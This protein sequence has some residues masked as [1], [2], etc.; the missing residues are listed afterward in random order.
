[1]FAG[2]RETSLRTANLASFDLHAPKLSFAEWRGCRGHQRCGAQ[3]FE[4]C[5]R[6]VAREGST[7]HPAQCTLHRIRCG[8]SSDTEWCDST[9][10]RPNSSHTHSS[11]SSA[12]Y[13]GIRARPD[14]PY[15]PRPP[16]PASQPW[17]C[18][19]RQ[20][21]EVA[22]DHLHSLVRALRRPEVVMEAASVGHVALVSL[23]AY[24]LGGLG[25]RV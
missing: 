2:L 4:R 1:M 7:V 14:R 12:L 24:S 19:H 6:W 5:W 10:L 21:A 16:I 23:A 9:R 8:T 18:L 3:A 11:C 13:A 15:F 25:F 17:R 20:P 22:V